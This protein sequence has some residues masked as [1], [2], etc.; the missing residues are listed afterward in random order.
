LYHLLSWNEKATKDDSRVN[1]FVDNGCVAK[2][3]ALGKVTNS[4]KS[5]TNENAKTLNALAEHW[6]INVVVI[7]RYS[8]RCQTQN[9][10]VYSV[11]DYTTFA[12]EINDRLF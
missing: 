1:P 6:R 5:A 8:F 10:I 11:V 3:L 12:D 2:S 9:E 7:H 4:L